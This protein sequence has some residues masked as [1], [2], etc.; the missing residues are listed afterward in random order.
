VAVIAALKSSRGRPKFKENNI[1]GNIQV[2][3][4]LDKL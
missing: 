2:A 4:G 1:S 3:I